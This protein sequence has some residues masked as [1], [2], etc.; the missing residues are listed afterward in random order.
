MVAVPLRVFGTGVEVRDHLLLLKWMLFTGVT[1]FGFLALW[2][3]N[4]IQL[5]IASDISYISVIIVAVYALTCLHCLAITLEVSREVNAA[6][7][8]REQ[9]MRGT[10]SYRVVGDRVLLSDGAELLPGVITDHIRNIVVK[11]SH[12]G[13]KTIDQTPLLRSL[14]DGLRSKQALG[15]FAADLELKLGL[16]GT[17]VGFIYMLVPLNDLTDFSV[18]AMRGV[19][20]SMS[21]GMGIA[22]Y[23]TLAGL[24]AA[25]LI[26][27]QYYF[28]DDS[29]AGLFGMTTELTEIYV[30]PVLDRGDHGSV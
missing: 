23:T 24:V 16:L 2:N 1:L 22:L 8:V 9:I 10:D 15:I 26:K 5:M 21:T 6:H 7:R 14:A 28:V 30:V 29:T 20:T 25:I 12:A 13:G 4:L 18:G 11:T 19:L 3:F 27:I 17:I